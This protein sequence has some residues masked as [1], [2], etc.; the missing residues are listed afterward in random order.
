[1]YNKT[2]IWLGVTLGS[3]A[4][5][6]IPG[7]WGANFLSLSGPGAYESLLGT[8]VGGLAGIWVATKLSNYF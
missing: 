6:L 7:L 8:L 3:T 5:S 4:G 1:M 2:L